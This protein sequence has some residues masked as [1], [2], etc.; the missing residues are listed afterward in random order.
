MPGAPECFRLGAAIEHYSLNVKRDVDIWSLGCVLSEVATWVV[1]N[2]KNV[3]EYRNQRRDETERTGRFRSGDYCFHDGQDGLLKCV[4]HN[5]DELVVRYVKAHDYVT[6]HVLKLVQD[7]M[8]KP[9]FNNGRRSA[10]WLYGEADTKLKMVKGELMKPAPVSTTSVVSSESSVWHPSSPT[11][12]TP[13]PP[14]GNG[15]L[16]FNPPPQPPY[17]PDETNSR[18]FVPRILSNR[19]ESSRDTTGNQRDHPRDFSGTEYQID[20]RGDNLETVAS[21]HGRS[22]TLP[23]RPRI[24]MNSATPPLAPNQLSTP[25]VHLPEQPNGYSHNDNVP[26]AYT[27]NYIT[28]NTPALGVSSLTSDNRPR[29]LFRTTAIEGQV[30]QH[31]ADAYQ[32]HSESLLQHHDSP[33][34][35]PVGHALH[36]RRVTKDPKNHEVVNMP[37]EHRLDGL[38]KRDHVRIP[39][40]LMYIY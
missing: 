13:R 24:S 37:S 22:S 2:W 28:Q 27:S 40:K 35:W 23:Q 18:L 34:V 26:S 33:P 9:S 36:W 31:L 8:L 4:D 17:H 3:L 1:C 10:L 21:L 16:N 11:L 15:P 30:P 7:A 12:N 25:F 5:H 20:G 6:E 19:D 29:S 32:S 39:S 14:L 38:D